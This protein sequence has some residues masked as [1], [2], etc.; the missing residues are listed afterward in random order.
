LI[1]V[2]FLLVQYKNGTDF[3]E[4]FVALKQALNYIERIF[5]LEFIYC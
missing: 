2:L 1:T 5:C 4:D 3:I